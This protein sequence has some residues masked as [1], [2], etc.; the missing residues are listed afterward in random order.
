MGTDTR[1]SSMNAI[2]LKSSHPR[3]E[4]IRIDAWRGKRGYLLPNEYSRISKNKNK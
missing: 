1:R 2:K 4:N 3:I